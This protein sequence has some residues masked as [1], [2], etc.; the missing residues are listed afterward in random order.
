[1]DNLLQCPSF[2][3]KMVALGELEP[4]DEL[5][6]KPNRLDFHEK[7]DDSDGDKGDCLDCVL[8]FHYAVLRFVLSSRK[9][10]VKDGLSN[11]LN[12]WKRHIAH[13]LTRCGFPED[14]W[15]VLEDPSRLR[16]DDWFNCGLIACMQLWCLFQRNVINFVNVPITEFRARVVQELKRLFVLHESGLWCEV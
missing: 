10:Y 4:V 12:T 9:V 2:H 15:T 6:V 3:A 8:S 5:D 1:M 13:I 16:Q 7:D 14:N 11:P